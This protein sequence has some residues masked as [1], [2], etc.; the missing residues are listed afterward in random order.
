M[1]ARHCRLAAQSANVSHNAEATARLSSTLTCS[2]SIH[3]AQLSAVDT[4][5]PQ[6]RR[7]V[8]G[9]T[10]DHA[11]SSKAGMQAWVI[12]Q[13]QR[14]RSASTSSS[15]HVEPRQDGEALRDAQPRSNR[16]RPRRTAGCRG[17]ARG[18]ATVL[19]QQT[20]PRRAWKHSRHQSAKRGSSGIQEKRAMAN[21]TSS[22]TD[23]LNSPVQRAA[24]SSRPF[25]AAASC[26]GISYR[27]MWCSSTA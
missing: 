15:L 25:E 11:P 22:C 26:P 13:Y 12:S 21:A 2:L 5:I 19:P 27:A 14:T 18:T 4:C 3:S 8:T 23:F 7:R 1:C 16:S 9:T 24:S 10:E 20:L 6:R 17:S